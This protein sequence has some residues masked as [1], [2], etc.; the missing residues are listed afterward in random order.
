MQGSVEPDHH[1]ACHGQ[2]LV[3]ENSADQSALCHQV[4][5]AEIHQGQVTPVIH[6]G[7]GVEIVGPHP[8]GNLRGSKRRVKTGGERSEENA[9]RT[10]KG[11]HETAFSA[12]D[13]RLKGVVWKFHHRFAAHHNR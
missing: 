7:V 5:S 2:P 11:I 10:N 6:M 1:P 4:K 12:A 8:H 3:F 13:D 9:P